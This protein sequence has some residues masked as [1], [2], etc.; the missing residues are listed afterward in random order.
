MEISKEKLA[1]LAVPDYI[2]YQR[3]IRRDKIIYSLSAALYFITAYAVYIAGLIYLAVYIAE[4]VKKTTG[5]WSVCI[6]IIAFYLAAGSLGTIASPLSQFFEFLVAKIRRSDRRETLRSLFEPIEL[7]IERDAIEILSFVQAASS[8]RMRQNRRAN[9]ELRLK[10]KWRDEYLTELN[11][12]KKN[13]ELNSIASDIFDEN[14]GYIKFNATKRN[15]FLAFKDRL[16]NS[17][18]EYRTLLL[19]A[20]SLY[21]RPSSFV[22]DTPDWV[23]RFKKSLS[24]RATPTRSTIR[25]A[26]PLGLSPN[27][28]AG[29]KP[30]EKRDVPNLSV[31]IR[32]AVERETT[33]KT[34]SQNSPAGQSEIGPPS[35]LSQEDDLNRRNIS[36]VPLRR[37][38]PSHQR[39]SRISPELYKKMADLKMDI[40]R[41]GE[42]LALAW[43]KQRV[44]Q[45]EGREYLRKVQHSSVD[46]GDGLGY[47]IQSIKNGKKIYIEVKTTT[48]DFQPGLFFTQNEYTTMK[49]LGDQYFLFRIYRFIPDTNLGDLII[50][51]GS[52]K[53]IDY[54][55]FDPNV[56]V[57]RQKNN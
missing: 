2:E 46:V 25:S 32:K 26:N 9:E 23:D 49:K 3:L 1:A 55:D 41:R 21:G 36:E 6:G 56:Y 43:E 47:D 38:T 15:E 52:K 42:L 45:E 44:S 24:Q 7:E 35:L 14:I 5:E 57:L 39:I 37:R 27:V 30:S 8:D 33:S 40:G 17:F 48:G 4:F 10:R 28:L 20:H 51:D 11:S 13:C 18:L 31:S 16:K 34:R 53:I 22:I 19:K 29:E 12:V 50:F 54:F